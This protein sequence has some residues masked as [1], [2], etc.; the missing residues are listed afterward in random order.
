MWEY[1]D[2][3]DAY[4]RRKAD[5]SE[6]G[7]ALWLEIGSEEERHWASRQLPNWERGGGEFGKSRGREW[8]LRSTASCSA[9]IE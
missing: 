2:M 5:S 8:L 4:R 3:R 1:S 6:I 9:V 7:G